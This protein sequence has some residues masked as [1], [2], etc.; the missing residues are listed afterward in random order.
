MFFLNTLMLPMVLLLKLF[1][2]NEIGV[3]EK[4]SPIGVQIYF[5]LK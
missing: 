4:K 5:L 1:L 2:K 3:I